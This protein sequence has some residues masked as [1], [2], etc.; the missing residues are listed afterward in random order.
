MAGRVST[1]EKRSVKW[2]L[3]GFNSGRARVVRLW[4]FLFGHSRRFAVASIPCAGTETPSQSRSA[5]RAGTCAASS[6]TGEPKPA[7]QS[8]R[9][10]AFLFRVSGSRTRQAKCRISL[11]KFSLA[12]PARAF[13]FLKLEVF[14]AFPERL[15]LVTWHSAPAGRN[16]PIRKIQAF[17]PRAP[18]EQKSSSN[19]GFLLR[20]FETP[21]L[22]S[23]FP[24]IPHPIPKTRVHAILTE[25]QK[26][27]QSQNSRNS[28]KAQKKAA[29]A[30]GLVGMNGFEPSTT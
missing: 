8:V 13:R 12:V 30:S 20:I 5:A 18:T 22:R 10:S 6:R 7:A 14:A 4:N 19:L 21:E 9:L 1:S 24:P 27:P 16:V 2:I 15:N 17:T 25:S 3:E 28:A 23:A 29:L 11:P 26:I